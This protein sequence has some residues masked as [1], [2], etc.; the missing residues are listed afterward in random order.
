MDVLPTRE[1]PERRLAKRWKI[2]AKDEED[3]LLEAQIAENEIVK[4][5]QS[6]TRA[7]S[8]KKANRELVVL[9]SSD[10]SVEK[11]DAATWVTAKD[12]NIEPTLQM[13]EGVPLAVPAESPME[14]AVEP[15]EERTETTS[16]SFLSL[17]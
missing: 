13:L 6:R 7:R 14:V 2:L 8:K 16:P 12:K 1:R 4:I 11:T 5:R 9:D 17:E 15:S 3:P 10:G